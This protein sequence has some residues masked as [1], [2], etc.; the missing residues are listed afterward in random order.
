MKNIRNKIM[1]V[2]VA[3]LVFSMSMTTAV[4]FRWVYL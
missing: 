1:V 4:L 3:I 2:A